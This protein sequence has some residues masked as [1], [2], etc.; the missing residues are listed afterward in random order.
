LARAG[1]SPSD[2]DYVNAHGTG[3]PLNDAM[4]A[5]ALRKA[6]GTEADRVP[7]SS[8][9]GQIGHTLGASGAVEAAVT[10]LAI[11]RGELPPTGGLEDPDPE[12]NLVHVIGKGKRAPVR[13]ALSNSFG[14]GGTDTVLL[15]TRP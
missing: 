13:A 10:V 5:A 12:C 8:C 1:L 4:E 6:L 11:V 2:L 9:K 14:F 7:V 3:T 15:F